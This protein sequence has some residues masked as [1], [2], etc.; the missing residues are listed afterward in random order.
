MTEPADCPS[1]RKPLPADAPEGMC[2][3]CMLRAGFETGGRRSDAAP[4]PDAAEIARKL[5]QFDVLGPLGRGGMGFVWRARQKALDRDVALKVLG[6][7]AAAAPGFAERFRREAKAL[8]RLDHPNIVRVYDSGEADGVFWIAME[9]VE[10]TN[11]RQAIA[12]RAIRPRETLE[13]VRQ[14]CDALEYAHAQGVVHRDIKPENILIS[15]DGRVRVAD[16][17]IAKIAGA[18]P[19][20]GLTMHGQVMGTAH[21]MAPEQVEHPQTVDHRA[22]IYSLGVV[23]YE[24]LT[25]ELPIGRFAPPS[26]KVQIDVRLDEIVL[27]TLEKER[28]TRYQRAGEVRTSVDAVGD[29]GPRAP[30]VAACDAPTRATPPW[31][32]SWAASGM[33]V[34]FAAAMW[35]LAIQTTND[36]FVVPLAAW[37]VAVIWTTAKAR[38]ASPWPWCERTWPNASMWTIAGTVLAAAGLTYEMSANE[39]H[40][41][42]YF[43]VAIPGA[44]LALAASTWADARAPE[45]AQPR[46]HPFVARS[47]WALLAAVAL[48][49]AAFLFGNVLHLSSIALTMLAIGAVLWPAAWILALAAIVGM[50]RGRGAWTG[51]ALSITCIV[52]P[53]AAAAAIRWW[54]LQVTGR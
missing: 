41:S 30:D 12:A 36:G 39:R 49:G 7:E 23:F 45:L 19:D 26:A 40:Q 6:P 43:P 46:R 44:V 53:I 5:P 52:I 38:A 18:A 9:L 37:L 8:A 20:D 33:C 11:L 2:P 16:F 48:R 22:D 4:V 29:G 1:C 34:A 10:G 54:S 28:E 27:R 47:L 42:W 25:G 17:G 15:T 32:R 14:I 21:Y 50:V 3:E 13:I 31:M 35:A 51:L 24:L